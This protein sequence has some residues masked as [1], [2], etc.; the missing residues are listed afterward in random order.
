MPKVIKDA[1]KAQTKTVSLPASLWADVEKRWRDRWDDRS[2]YLRELITRDL[3]TGGLP[4]PMDAQVLIQSA[5]VL[6]GEVKARE[7]V[8]YVGD[9]DQ[10]TLLAALLE[11]Y[12]ESLRMKPTMRPATMS[13]NE[14][15]RDDL[16]ST[17]ERIERGR[18]ETDHERRVTAV[19]EAFIQL[20]GHS[21]A[22][23]IG[24]KLGEILQGPLTEP[25][26]ITAMRQALDAR[27]PVTVEIT[28]HHASGSPYRVRLGIQPTNTGFI[29]ETEP[30]PLL[31][32]AYEAA[33]TGALVSAGK[34]ADAPPT[35]PAP[36]P[37]AP[38][39]GSAP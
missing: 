4:E 34:K 10:P 22:Q 20:C 6:I 23:L 5:R 28:N 2:D 33:V 24:K 19:N 14:P 11:G 30:L 16:P 25:A 36:K 21:S 39:K 31:P 38:R 17:T 15:T 18:V 9:A 1:D 3:N 7:L 27:R 29:G 32:K 35:A 37:A 13:L 12:L 8:R 26:A